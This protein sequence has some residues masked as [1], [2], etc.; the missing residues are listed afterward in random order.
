[1]GVKLTIEG[2]LKEKPKSQKSLTDCGRAVDEKLKI[3]SHLFVIE[4]IEEHK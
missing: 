2:Y 3:N 4:L 1:V